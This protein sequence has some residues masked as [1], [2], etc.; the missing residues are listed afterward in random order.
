MERTYLVIQHCSRCGLG[1]DGHMDHAH[2]TLARDLGKCP[3][4]DCDA[5]RA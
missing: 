1:P 2:A 3:F 4:G 5:Y